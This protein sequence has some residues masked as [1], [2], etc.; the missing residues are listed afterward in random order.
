MAQYLCSFTVINGGTYMSL[1]DIIMV[2]CKKDNQRAW[3]TWDRLD[4]E[5]KKELSA[6]R[7]RQRG[8]ASAPLNVL[9]REEVGSKRVRNDEED[10]EALPPPLSTSSPVRRLAPSA[11]GTTKKTTRPCLRPSQ[12]PRL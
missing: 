8:P 5:K 7:R 12:R 4:E 9:A 1:C 2:V 3:E 10:N 11:C 6:F